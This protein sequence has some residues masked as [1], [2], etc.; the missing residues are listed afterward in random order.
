MVIGISLIVSQNW[1]VVTGTVQ[2]CTVRAVHSNSG[3]PHFDRTCVMTWQEGGRE[4][5]GSVDFG[6]VQI[7]NGQ[8][9][10]LRVHGNDAVLPTPRWAAFVVTAIG[11]ALIGLAVFVLLR[12]RQRNRSAPAITITG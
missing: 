1:T 9:K 7:V 5:T 8:S 11:L 12:A 4:H 3:S 10:T 6:T 2:S